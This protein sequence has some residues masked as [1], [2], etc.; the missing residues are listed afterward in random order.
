MQNK[1]KEEKMQK[2]KYRESS[3]QSVELKTQRLN[4]W[5]C[6]FIYWCMFPNADVSFFFLFFVFF[7]VGRWL[8]IIVNKELGFFFFLL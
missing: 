6:K 4:V 2:K 3:V 7:G 8:V 5:Q 1:K